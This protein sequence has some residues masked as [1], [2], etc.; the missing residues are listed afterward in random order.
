MSRT[1][2]ALVLLLTGLAPHAAEAELR[3][4][5]TTTDIASLA[6]QLGG[7]DTE[8]KAIAR[9]YQDP[10]YLEAKPS[11]VV[12]L[13]R[14]DLLAY[15]GLD[16][17]VGW[18]PLLIDSA[19]NDRLLAGAPGN[20]PLSKG[21]RALEVPTGEVSRAGGDI[22]P[23]GNPH[24]WLDPRNTLIMAQTLADR[25]ALLDPDHADAIEAR[26]ADFTHRMQEKIE[27][28]SA[29][30]A[31]FAGTKIVCY[32][33]QWEYLLDWLGIETIDYIENKPGIPPSPRHLQDLRRR[34]QNEKIPLILMSNFF[35]PGAA[36]TLAR[37]T[38][39]RL[40][41]LPPSVG[42]EDGVDDLFD[43]FDRLV[44]RLA[45]TLGNTHE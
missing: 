10:H 19:R 15:V 27:T 21:I 43:L 32:H 4:V 7:D 13:R 23:R 29:R 17:E 28:W 20:L 16:L 18:L 42:G 41:V 1:L 14:A 33:K 30:M 37:E 6:R 8:V 45:E 39:A 22:H 40:L 11:Y 34:M 25:M 38:G 26:R 31:P 12:L 36:E 5:T 24:Y 44:S 35:D 9:G 2:M 3:V